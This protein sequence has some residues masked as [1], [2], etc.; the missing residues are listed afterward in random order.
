[1]EWS[2]ERPLRI[3]I[4]YD[5]SEKIA[6]SVCCESIM[7][8]ASVPVSF[9]PIG[10]TNA[11]RSFQRPRGDKDSTEFAITR[12]LAPYM[13]DYEGHSVFVDCDVVF[14]T[15][16]LDLITE[17]DKENVVSVV[18]HNYTPA[19]DTKFLGNQQLAY[20]KKNWSSLMVFNNEK[21]MHLTPEYVE[22]THGLDLHQF[23]WV[24]ESKIGEIDRS[25]N[26]LVGEYDDKAN[27]SMIHFTNGGPYFPEYK[28]KSYSD[29]WF[30]CLN[31][32]LKPLKGRFE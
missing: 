25:W 13:S 11:P 1:M 21:C 31:E 2:G 17:I 10:I 3:F 24:E 8:H 29:I 14:T 32:T 30:D 23:K 22:K 27:P 4:G 19:N 9:T 26:H 18:K 20:T 5:S 16:I 12:F 15:D 28:E 7:Q 6:Y